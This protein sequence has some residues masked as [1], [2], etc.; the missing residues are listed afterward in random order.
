MLLKKNQTA[1]RKL[2]QIQPQEWDW[3]DQV[4]FSE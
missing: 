4:D 3:R 2:T 1:R